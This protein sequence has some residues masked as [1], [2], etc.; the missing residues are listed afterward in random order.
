MPKQSFETFEQFLE[1]LKTRKPSPEESFSVIIELEEK[2]KRDIEE[3]FEKLAGSHIH[4]IQAKI[5]YV[6]GLLDLVV[7]SKGAFDYDNALKNAIQP[8]EDILTLYHKSGV[9]TQLKQPK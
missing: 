9:S 7:Q 4:E 3:L 1:A 2:I 8:L 5:G 6:K